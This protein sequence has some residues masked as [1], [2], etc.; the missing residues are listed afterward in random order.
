MFPQN[1]AQGISTSGFVKAAMDGR[2]PI[3]G[4][5]SNMKIG[6]MVKI[7]KSVQFC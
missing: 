7:A 4:F 2:V 1:G 3:L 6:R 5:I